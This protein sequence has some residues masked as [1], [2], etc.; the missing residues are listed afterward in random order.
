MDRR[1]SPLLQAAS[2]PFLRA[3]I[4]PWQFARWKLR[5]DPVFVALLRRGLL[6]DGGRLLDLG[7]G[8][9]V[10]LALLA[11]AADQYERGQWPVGWPP[12]P[13]NLLLHGFECCADRVMTAQRTLAGRATVSQCDIRTAD[14]PAGR[15][16]VLFDVLMYLERPEQQRVLEKAA[17]AVEPGGV[18]LLRETD[19]EGGLAFQVS[20][21]SE[22]LMQAGRGRLRDRLYYRSALDWNRLLEGLDFSVTVEPVSVGTPFANVLFVARKKQR[23]SNHR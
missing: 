12:P 19:V 11:A 7:C 5:L 17:A 2:R 1:V 10:L 4:Y 15:V 23:S 6:P 22:R 13:R 16:T 14:F 18:L 9:G 21:W 20:R 8:Q 3:G